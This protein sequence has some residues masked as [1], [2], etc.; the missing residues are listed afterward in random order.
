ML[1]L[2]KLLASRGYCTRSAARSFLRKFAV[3]ENGVRLYR[4]DQRV[5]GNTV[6]IEGEPADPERIDVL[7]NKPVG[8]VCSHDEGEGAL[9]YDLLPA[10]WMQRNPSVTSVG[11][12]DKETSGLLIITDDGALVHRLTSPKKQ[13]EKVYRVELAQPLGGHEAER[14]ASGSMMLEKDPKP[15]LP[16]KLEV[17]GEREARLSIVEGRYHQVRRMFAAV[18]NRVERLHRERVGGLDL[19]DLAPGAWRALTPQDLAAIR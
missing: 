16:A 17:L 19:G 14:F 10:R 3:C 4:E 8:V 6:T 9:I 11:R 13:V 12:L 18:G 5:D 1:R 7:M 2:D 15:L